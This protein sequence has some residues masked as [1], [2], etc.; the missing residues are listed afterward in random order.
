MIL[1]ARQIHFNNDQIASKIYPPIILLAIE[2]VTEMMDVAEM[3]SNHTGQFEIKIAERTEKLETH[4]KILE[5]Q[6]DD[7]KLK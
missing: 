3:L 4:I 1:N 5:K 2:D 6:I 7:L